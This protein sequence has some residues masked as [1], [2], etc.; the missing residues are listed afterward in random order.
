[1]RL[2]PL[3]KYGALAAS[4][5]A[6]LSYPV[7]VGLRPALADPIP[8]QQ[9]NPAPTNPVAIG[10]RIASAETALAQS[11]G[12]VDAAESELRQEAVSSFVEGGSARVTNS[13]FQGQGGYDSVLREEYL[14]TLTGDAQDAVRRL[15]RSRADLKAE[16]ARLQGEL[17]LAQATVAQAVSATGDGT[18][19]TDQDPSAT[20]SFTIS[21]PPDF[22]VALLRTLGDPLTT[23]NIGAIV[24]W[25]TREGG[26]WNSPA[27]FN[28]LNT[29]M[30]MPGSHAINGAGVQSYTSW[31]QGLTATIATLNTGSYRG[32]LAAL[33][34]GSSVGAV[35]GAVAASPWGTH[36]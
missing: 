30:K 34:A 33:S 4:V 25:C 13:L 8:Q 31:S 32:I 16:Q 14:A 12:Q 10:L 24:A 15:V 21:G 19:L 1:V 23:S 9:A 3:S 7:A 28:P 2:L 20:A 36:F 6:S 22:A 35:E 26:A 18:T 29:S 17:Q 11:Q 27:R 5:V